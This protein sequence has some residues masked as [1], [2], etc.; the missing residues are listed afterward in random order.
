MRGLPRQARRSALWALP[1][2]AWRA[3]KGRSWYR[4]ELRIYC[5]PA[6]RISVLP[7]PRLLQRD[8]I[9]DLDRYE[10]TEHAQMPADVY[11]DVARQR[12]AQGHH[13]YTLVEGRRLLHYGW[14]IDRQ[15]RGEDLALGQVFFPPP[16]SAALYDYFTHPQA[17]GHGLYRQALCQVLH[18]AHEHAG[19]RQ[20]YIYVYADNHA[21]RHVVERIGFHYAGS[22]VKERRFFTDRHYAVAAHAGFEAGLLTG[23]RPCQT[24]IR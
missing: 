4:R 10:R 6:E 14:L 5:Y 20:A 21:S 19:A 16:D 11:R 1:A 2:W 22:L 24:V 12:L 18:D 13:L 17:R 7:R 23:V 15:D 9:D 3:A 8:C